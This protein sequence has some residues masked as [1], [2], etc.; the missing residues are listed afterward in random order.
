VPH[1]FGYTGSPAYHGCLYSEFGHAR[2][3]VHVD[4][5]NHPSK[6]SMTAWFTKATGDD[7]DDTVERAAHK[8]LTEFCERHLPGL[9]GPT[10]ALF[11]V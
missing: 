8:A 2:Y 6:P 9:D 10:V 11:P 4:I 3:K 7:L 5:L 1:H